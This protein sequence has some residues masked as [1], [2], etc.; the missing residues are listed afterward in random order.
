MDPCSSH[1][2]FTI[3]QNYADNPFPHTLT[4]TMFT[5]AVRHNC[6]A[7][8]LY[9]DVAQLSLRT[10]AGYTRNQVPYLPELQPNWRCQHLCHVGFRHLQIL[11]QRHRQRSDFV[12]ASRGLMRIFGLQ[13]KISEMYYLPSV[14]A[15][16]VLHEGNLPRLQWHHV[17]LQA[18]I[19]TK[20]SKHEAKQQSKVHWHHLDERSRI[21][22]FKVVSHWKT[23]IPFPAFDLP[24]SPSLAVTSTWPKQALQLALP[25]A[26][27][28]APLM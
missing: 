12:E 18:Q 19:I 20:I 17:G 22:G 9:E 2:P 14:W 26:A 8:C 28:S 27:S 16:K 25:R 1:V 7:I 13:L 5:M 23:S 3:Y 4:C 15:H 10:A 11:Y 6:W 21:W 24:S